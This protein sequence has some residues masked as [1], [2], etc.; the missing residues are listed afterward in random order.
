VVLA[1]AGLHAAR[2]RIVDFAKLRE[3]ALELFSMLRLFLAIVRPALQLG[4]VRLDLIVL[5]LLD[6]VWRY[7]EQFDL[8]VASA[9]LLRCIQ[10]VA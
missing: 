9:L 3:L 10:T 2:V 6:C 1:G 7:G 8:F 5:V 4:N